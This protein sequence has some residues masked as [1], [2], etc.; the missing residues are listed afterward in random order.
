VVGFANIF[1]D[2]K[3]RQR[4]QIAKRE[5]SGPVLL[6]ALAIGPRVFSFQLGNLPA[7]LRNLPFQNCLGHKKRAEQVPAQRD[8]STVIASC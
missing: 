1:I 2:G 7:H 5:R 4:K 6:F 8:G 3:I